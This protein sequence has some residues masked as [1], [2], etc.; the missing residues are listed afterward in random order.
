MA[1]RFAHEGFEVMIPDIGKTEGLGSGHHFALRSSAQF[2]GGVAVGNRKVAMLLQLYGDALDYVRG[3]EMVDPSK[4]A[5]F[6][7]SYGA[8]S[9][10]ALAAQDTRLAAVALAYP[11]PVRPPDLAKLVTVPLLCLRGSADRRVRE[12][13]NPARGRSIGDEG[14]VRV[15]RD[16][17]R[18]SRFPG[19]GSLRR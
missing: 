10:L 19:S 12:G 6:G 15:H 8:S 17:G 1:I 9:A 14:F 13:R 11:M 7:T 18:T 4:A 5:V 2:R 16:P 3:R